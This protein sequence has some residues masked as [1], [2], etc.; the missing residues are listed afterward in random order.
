MTGAGAK[1]IRRVAVTQAHVSYASESDSQSPSTARG[2]SAS[3]S[4]VN[5]TWRYAYNAAACCAPSAVASNNMAVYNDLMRLEED[6]QS[7]AAQYHERMQA[8]ESKPVP[9]TKKHYKQLKERE[10]RKSRT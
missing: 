3:R 1:A 10:E 8:E 5:P 9:K 2:S 7:A 4:L 6:L